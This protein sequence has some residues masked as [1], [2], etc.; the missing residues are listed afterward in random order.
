MDP[1]IP[2]VEATG[3]Y[4]TTPDQESQTIEQVEVLEVLI[5]CQLLVLP[6]LPVRTN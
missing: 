4:G 5:Q 3:A 1:G 2:S 6:C